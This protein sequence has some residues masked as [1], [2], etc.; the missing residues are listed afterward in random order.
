MTELREKPNEN[1]DNT[2]T[3]PH[4]LSSLQIP[5]N[6]VFAFIDPNGAG[7]TTTIKLL[8][9]LTRTTSS[10]RTIIGHDFTIENKRILV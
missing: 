5:K 3:N 9:G 4:R 7:K 6:S 2:P 8:R 10:D 1:E